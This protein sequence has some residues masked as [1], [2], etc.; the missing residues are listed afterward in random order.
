MMAEECLTRYIS[1]PTWDNLNNIVQEFGTKWG[2]P[3]CFG[4][5]DGSHIPIKAPADFHADYYRKGWYS[6]IMQA[7]VDSSYKFFDVNVGWPVK[8]PDA[9][10]F[11]NSAIYNKVQSRNL[12]DDNIK[13]INGVRVPLFLVADAAYPLFPWVMKP[14]PDNGQLIQ[15]KSHFNY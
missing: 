7:I 4:A 14:F 2:F 5:V 3:Q 15:E 10:V 12:M 11:S 13:E 9:R 1:I 8:V 6:I